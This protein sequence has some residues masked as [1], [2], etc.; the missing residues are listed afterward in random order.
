MEARSYVFFINMEEIMD[1]YT[2]GCFEFTGGAGCICAVGGGDSGC[3]WVQDLE[4]ERGGKQKK[5]V[6]KNTALI[7]IKSRMCQCECTQK[8][9]DKK[10]RLCMINC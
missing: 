6:W 3:Q 10:I 9:E 4:G 1:G 5:N 2:P 8:L 7:N